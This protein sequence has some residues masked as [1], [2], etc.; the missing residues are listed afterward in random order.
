MVSPPTR[1][2]ARKQ[3][4]DYLERAELCYQVTSLGQSAPRLREK[5]R[6]VRFIEC[7]HVIL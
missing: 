2:L 3:R 1:N 4:G 6:E 7:F 5:G